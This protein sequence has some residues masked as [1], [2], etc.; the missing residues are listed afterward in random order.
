MDADVPDILQKKSILLR[1][2]MLASVEHPDMAVVDEFISGSELVGCV[3]KTGMW[4]PKFQPVTI[5]FDELRDVARLERKEIGQQF[6]GFGDEQLLEKVW[7]KTLGET[8]AGA[9]VGPINL[10]DVPD[11]FPLNRRFGKVQDQKVKCIDDYARSAVTAAVQ[12]CENPKPHTLEVFA[13]IC[14]S[15]MGSTPTT[16]TWK[17]RAFDLVGAY[18]QCAVHPASRS[19][20]TLP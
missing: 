1:K 2:T 11:T 16:E 5:S 12:T 6:V 10:D 18:R 17:G 20:R 14:V 19:S 3:D 13:A 9:L 4:P 8:E 15:V 7:M